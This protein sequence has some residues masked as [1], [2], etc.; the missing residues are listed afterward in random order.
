MEQIYK[1]SDDEKISKL[2]DT[3]IW[4][5][6]IYM[7]EFGKLKLYSPSLLVCL[8]YVYKNNLLNDDWNIYNLKNI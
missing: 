4:D 1:E 8:N 2:F 7:F 6:Q 5:N 3:N